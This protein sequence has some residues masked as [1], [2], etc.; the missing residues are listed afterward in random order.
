MSRG[1]APPEPS[2]LP[3]APP[4]TTPALPSAAPVPSG[5]APVPEPPASAAQ[6]AAEPSG[7]SPAHVEPPPDP[8]GRETLQN[9]VKAK[10]WP[11]ATDALIALAE[12]DPAALRDPN[13]ARAARVLAVAFGAQQSDRSDRIFG[14]LAERFGSAGIDVLYDIIE[15]RGS[16][17]TGMRA[18][19][20]L[21]K[22]EVAARGTPQV[23]IAFE[24][25]DLPCDKK[26]EILDR[27]VAGGDE[28]ALLVLEKVVRPCFK[29]SRPVDE[30]IRK[31]K[32]RLKAR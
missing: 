5:E 29:Q 17:T 13:V 6:P 3:A 23:R 4:A 32:D 1:S 10:Q 8:A 24:L 22:P 20:L 15:V 25:R 27:A 26:L 12:R 21:R 11:E 28:R 31:L 14:A 19:E 18:T 9:A 30:A 7:S 2:P 16:S